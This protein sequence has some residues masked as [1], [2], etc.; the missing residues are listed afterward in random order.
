MKRTLLAFLVLALLAAP[1]AVAVEVRLALDEPTVLPGTPTGLTVTVTNTE[2]Y[3]L[4]L[5]PRLWLVGTN[6]QFETF[7]V[8]IYNAS[9]NAAAVVA[10]AERDVPA[11]GTREFRFDPSV[12]LVGSP[13]FTDGRLSRPG[14]YRL[15]AVFAPEVMPDGT[16]NAAHAIASKEQGLTVATVSDDDTAVWRWMEQRRRGVWGQNAWMSQA[17]DFAKFKGAIRLSAVI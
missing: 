14:A 8:S 7:T 11:G 6:D 2:T 1:V 10:E 4:R 17:E 9:D 16:Y 13:W 5:P 15:Q 12:V 3:A